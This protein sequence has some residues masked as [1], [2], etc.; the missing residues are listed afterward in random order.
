V[1]ILLL[2]DLPESGKLPRMDHTL[3]DTLLEVM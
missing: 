1:R 2:T 3:R